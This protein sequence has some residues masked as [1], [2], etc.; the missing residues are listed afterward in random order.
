MEADDPSTVDEAAF[1]YPGPKPN[2]R[3]TGVVMLADKVEAATRTIRHPNEENIRAMINRIINSVIADHQFTECPLTFQEIHTIAD[4]FVTVLMGI[5]HQRIEYPQTRGLSARGA[6]TR[7]LSEG[8]PRREPA[9]L[10]ASAGT[11]T[12]ELEALS[13]DA[14]PIWSE[15]HAE[16][17]DETTDYESVRN[18]PHG[19]L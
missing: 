15:K 1:R 3:E 7:E 19:D 8:E 2:S 5:H 4:T 12:L 10:A 18:L 13:G 16:L 14:E 11:I 6:P 17:T 9:R